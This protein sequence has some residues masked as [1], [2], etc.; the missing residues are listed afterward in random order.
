MNIEFG[1]ER[2][3]VWQDAK[4]I[5]LHIYTITKGFPSDEKF[6]LTSQIRRAAVSVCSNLDEGCTR[7]TK[8]EQARFVEI[9]FGSLVELISQLELAVALDYIN[10]TDF[11]NL[12]YQSIILKRKLSSYR[13][14]ILA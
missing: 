14:S 13:K 1:Y 12:K 9:A 4:A 3:N 10:Y 5:T 11:E 8:K 7:T 6:G 2:L